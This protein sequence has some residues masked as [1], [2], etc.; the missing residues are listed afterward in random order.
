M[1]QK[2]FKK[3][4]HEK[5]GI[6]HFNFSTLEQLRG[7]AEATK[8][9]KAPV[10]VAVSQGEAEFLGLEQAVAM[11][12]ILENK[13]KHPLFLHLDHA[14]DL[15]YIKSAIN[16]GFDS[17]H[18]DGS[19]LS[20]KKNIVL[21]K[22]AA[23]YARKNNVLIE[24]ELGSLLIRKKDLTNPKQVKEFVNKTGVHSLAVAVG[25]AHGKYPKLEK[26]DFDLL[27]QIR[28]NTEAFLVLHG[29]SG[30]SLAQIRK[31]IKLGIQKININTDLRIT[32]KKSLLKEIKNSKK[33][34]P[35]NILPFVEKAIQ[36]KVE[37][38]I[39]LFGGCNR[40]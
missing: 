26:L 11:V 2:I 22:K 20:F 33:V 12:R 19:H 9:L 31:A 34:K 4:Q 35:Y 18:C 10:I 37:K 24:G 14:K 23:L 5:W 25:S 13:I 15:D 29:A 1:L 39:R 17:V 8:K 32:W 30:V 38:Y 40:I 27:S 3:A 21:T 28:E 6:G 16:L 36:K 7:I